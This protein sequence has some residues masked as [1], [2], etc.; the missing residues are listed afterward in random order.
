MKLLKTIA[1]GVV[2]KTLDEKSAFRRVMK[3]TG[4]LD[5]ALKAIKNIAD[6]SIGET[7]GRVIEHKGL[8]MKVTF[9]DRERMFDIVTGW[10]GA[11]RKK[12]PIIENLYDRKDAI[13]AQCTWNPNQMVGFGT[14]SIRL[15]KYTVLKIKS[16]EFEKDERWGKEKHR[17]LTFAFTGV[18]AKLLTIWVRQKKY[19]WSLRK[20]MLFWALR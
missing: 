18:N 10:I 8:L 14:V 19:L 13:V 2:E 7:I 17:A 11:Q 15:D 6:G 4:E 12:Y 9:T 16:Y 5:I 1:S 3:A 20:F